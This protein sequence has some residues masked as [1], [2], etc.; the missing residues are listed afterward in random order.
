M[1]FATSD[2][3]GEAPLLSLDLLTS[4]GECDGVLVIETLASIV[5]GLV[6]GS[7][8]W[9][10]FGSLE[11]L[12]VPLSVASKI[13]GIWLVLFAG[14]LVEPLRLALGRFIRCEM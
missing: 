14:G 9:L 12:D 5:G 2:S 6:A 1:F 13:L 7:E 8:A 4:S 10:S 3:L 11:G